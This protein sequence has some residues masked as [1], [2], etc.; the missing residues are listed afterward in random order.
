CIASAT[1]TQPSGAHHAGAGAETRGARPAPAFTRE[2]A[3]RVLATALLHV[4]QL[5]VEDQRGVGR[6]H[7]RRAALAV[8]ERG[9]D[10]ELALAPHLHPGDALV[11]ALDDVGRA[12]LERER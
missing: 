1:A 2:G 5:D 12:D 7:A 3:P 10:G 9:R 4:D 11:P 8:A 6:D